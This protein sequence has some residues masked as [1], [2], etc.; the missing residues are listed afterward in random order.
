MKKKF[1]ISLFVVASLMLLAGTPGEAAPVPCICADGFLFSYDGDDYYSATR[2]YPAGRSCTNCDL[3][4][5]YLVGNYTGAP[6]P[7]G[8]ERCEPDITALRTSPEEK[9]T[10]PAYLGGKKID[11]NFDP[12][13]DYPD[14]E[15]A[16]ILHQEIRSFLDVN[17]TQ[18][19]IQVYYIATY[20]RQT[21]KF[22]LP[23]VG[24]ELLP[25]TLSAEERKAA[26]GPEEGETIVPINQ[27]GDRVKE[28][29]YVYVNDKD[30]GNGDVLYFLRNDV[31][32]A[33]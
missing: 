4:S 11:R 23:V 1:S 6:F 12:T 15:I 33:P 27:Y 8:H 22:T 29:T 28:H 20:N 10:R 2:Y 25:K 17:R 31:G 26:R 3:D 5:A 14:Q 24:F 13:A 9:K 32:Q 21:R 7:C 30:G 18:R 16:K 19:W